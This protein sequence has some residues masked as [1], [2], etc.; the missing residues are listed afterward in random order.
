MVGAGTDCRGL[1]AGD[2]ELETVNMDADYE[3]FATED[4]KEFGC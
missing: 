4:K 3:S 2:E 1:K